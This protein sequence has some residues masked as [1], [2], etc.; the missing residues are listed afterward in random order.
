[1]RIQNVSEE[2]FQQAVI[3]LKAKGEVTVNLDNSG[4]FDVMGTKGDFTFQENVL[5]IT[6]IDKP[7][8]I[9]QDLLEE[10]LTTFFQ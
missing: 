10:K 2:K 8:Y 9:P 3:E 6:I 5:N 1:M 7:W 4:S